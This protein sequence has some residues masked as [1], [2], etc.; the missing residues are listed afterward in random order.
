VCQPDISLGNR[1]AS[2]AATRR[3]RV[4]DEETRRRTR[5][6]HELVVLPELQDT[7]GLVIPSTLQLRNCSL[8][9]VV[10]WLRSGLT[11]PRV[12]PR[13]GASSLRQQG[14]VPPTVQPADAL[15][16]ADDA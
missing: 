9:P 7:Q 5:D 6:P 8:V 10:L 15:P 11:A 14:G 2:A 4:H 16:E 1:L 3:G 13:H 12:D